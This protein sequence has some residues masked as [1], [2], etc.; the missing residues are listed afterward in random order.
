MRILAS[1][2]LRV[3]GNRV[4]GNGDNEEEE[5]GG[6]VAAAAAAKGRLVTRLMKKN[7]VQNAIPILI[8]LK[9]YAISTDGHHCTLTWM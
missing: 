6:S 7:L 2:E 8:D 9:R 5:G 3:V 4:T 1:K